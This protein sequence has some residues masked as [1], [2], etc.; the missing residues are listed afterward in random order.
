MKK[1]IV[2]LAIMFILIS[3]ISFLCSVF[4]FKNI[5]FLELLDSAEAAVSGLYFDDN[6]SSFANDISLEKITQAKSSI[7]RLTDK[8]DRQSLLDEIDGISNLLN[9][10]ASIDKIF[11]DGI[12]T[13]QNQDIISKINEDFETVKGYNSKIYLS[14][15]RD[16][17]DINAQNRKINEVRD[18]VN[19]L[20]G[21]TNVSRDEY[22]AVLLDIFNVKNTSIKESLITSMK[23]VDSLIIYRESQGFSDIR[24]IDDSIIVDLKYATEDN[25]TGKK[26]Y[27][28]KN[29]IAR[30]GSCKKLAAAN[31]EVKALGYRIK[32]WDAYRPVYA[33]EALWEAYPDPNFV[34]M[35]DPTCSHELGVTF[36][37]TLCDLNGN[38]MIMQSSFDDFSE[39]AYRSFKRSDE[40]EKYYKILN[41][42]MVNAGFVGYFAEWWDYTD[43]DECNYVP[44]QVDPKLY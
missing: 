43:I 24:S 29:A 10:K 23:E 14:L 27:D 3:I 41:D 5:A 18:K 30:T 13:Q 36:D 2:W 42:A 9:I 11:E 16:L 15:K 34:A 22:D 19:D 39:R 17:E 25:F 21:R 1:N 37:V 26:I 33:Q 20:L 7:E 32:I 28:F 8:A 6:K 35:P 44:M 31:E 38:E 4:Y 40:E 12:L